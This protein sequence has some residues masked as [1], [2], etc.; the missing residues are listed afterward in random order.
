MVSAMQR[1]AAEGEAMCRDS[2]V[3]IHLRQRLLARECTGAPGLSRMG[4]RFKP[5]CFDEQLN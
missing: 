1:H 4:Y 5:L 3:L 2:V